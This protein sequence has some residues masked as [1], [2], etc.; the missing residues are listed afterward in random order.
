MP[1]YMTAA[2]LNILPAERKALIAFVQ[3]PALG[4]IVSV[5][6]KAHY[7]DQGHASDDEQAKV[8]EC[9][10]AGCVAGFVFAHA[11]HVQGL[12]SLRKMRSADDYIGEACDE[13]YDEETLEYEPVSELLTDLFSE[14]S[15]NRSLAEAKAV[16]DKMLRT[17]EVK[18][19]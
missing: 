9:G 19:K 8:N 2:Q 12:R 6:G 15:S 14:G 18:W 10:T 7:Y 11:L 5:N 16:V 3:A 17:G 13:R 4:R 1:K